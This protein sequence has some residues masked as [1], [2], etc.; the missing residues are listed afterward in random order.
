MMPN[1]KNPDPAELVRGRS[2]RVIGDLAGSLTMLKGLPL[3]YQRDLQEDKPALFDALG[4]LE[5]SLGVMAGLVASLAVDEQRMRAAAGD[6][7]TTATAVADAIVRHGIP[8]RTAHHVVG[9]IVAEADRRGSTL[10]A[11]PDEVFTGA[12]GADPDPSA[13]QLG[14]RPGIA[15]ELRAAA[16]IDAA[17][18][19]CDVIGGT[20]PARVAAAVAAAR[21]RIDTERAAAGTAA[22]QAG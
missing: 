6:G 13:A 21:T 9:R 19:S 3:A 18:A 16:G 2:G 1:K 5:A 22:Q 12:L 14:L 15:A 7:H 11:L 10:Q 17:L 8:F 4:T 20:A